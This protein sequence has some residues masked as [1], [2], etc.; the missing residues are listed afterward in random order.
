M[1][2]M[3]KNLPSNAGD[4]GLIPGWERSPGEGNAAHSSI[5]AGEFY[6]QRSLMGYSHGV[7]KSQT[8]LFRNQRI[9][10]VAIE[11]GWFHLRAPP[12]LKEVLLQFSFPTQCSHI[13]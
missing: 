6:G 1:A 5:L 13:L 4:Q 7:A 8:R 3:V 9:R 2:Q 11:G 12:V 10:E